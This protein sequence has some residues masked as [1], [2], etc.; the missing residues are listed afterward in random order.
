MKKI[1]A[2]TAIK[3]SAIK[4]RDN[5]ISTVKWMIS[6]QS[7]LFPFNKCIMATVISVDTTTMCTVTLLDD[8]NT[9]SNIRIPHHIHSIASGIL[10]GDTVF[11]EAINGDSSMYQVH[12][13]LK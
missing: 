8:T 2:D 7:K 3:W 11:I 5:I 9:R 13:V 4:L 6:T 1:T 10:A 12:S